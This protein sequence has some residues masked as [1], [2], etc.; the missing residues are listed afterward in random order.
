MG[1]LWLLWLSGAELACWSCKQFSVALLF[2]RLAACICCCG[3]LLA[4]SDEG[5]CVVN[6]LHDK[7]SSQQLQ[8]LTGSFEG[9]CKTWQRKQQGCCLGVILHNRMDSWPLIWR[10]IG[11]NG[12]AAH[13]S[14]P[15]LFW[16][17]CSQRC[18]VVTALGCVA[19]NHDRVGRRDA[20]QDWTARSLL[21][22][23]RSGGIREC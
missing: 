10:S 13:F 11:V 21:H 3:V 1:S 4:D 7:F 15:V 17:A 16:R 19:P 23:H 2:C 6:L 9:W 5:F 14:P 12:E 18:Q 20:R 22:N 8:S